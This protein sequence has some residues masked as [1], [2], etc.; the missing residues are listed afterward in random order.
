MPPYVSPLR[1]A[2]AAQTRQRILDAAVQVFGTSGYSGASLAVIAKEAGVSLETVKQNGPKAAL[3]LAG[4]DHAFA[5]AEG[6]G[7]LHGRELG[8]RAATLEGDEL[9]DFQ[10]AF[11]AEANKRAARL[12]PRLVEA[13]AGD[14]EVGRRLEQLQ[15]NRQADMRASIEMYRA[16]GVCHS[17]R[18]DA[19]LAAE[20]SFLISPEGYTQLVVEAGWSAKAYRAWLAR[21]VRRLILED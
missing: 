19:E 12:W 8:E 10:L 6:E 2:Q 17:E 7:P 15:R 11:V 14:A 13:A 20:L 1:E 21:A 16:K 18:P 3:L 4:F 5:G 9:L